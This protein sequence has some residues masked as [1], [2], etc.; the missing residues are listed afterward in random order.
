MPS[1]SIF[2]ISLATS[3]SSLSS[4]IASSFGGGFARQREVCGCISGACIVLGLLYGYDT[5]EV[6]QIKAEHY[7]RIQEVCRSF[8]E[9]YFNI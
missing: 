6:G 1:S 9:K 2:F 3:I 7:A 4:K 5:P 8:K